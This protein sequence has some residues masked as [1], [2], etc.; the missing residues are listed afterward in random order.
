MYTVAYLSL[1]DELI[2]GL[3]FQMEMMRRNGFVALW[4]GF[5]NERHGFRLGGAVFR[6]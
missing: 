6:N 1:I 4:H 5:P 3:S 2:S